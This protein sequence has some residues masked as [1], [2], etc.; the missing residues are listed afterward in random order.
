MKTSSRER[1]KLIAIL[2]QAYWEKENIEIGEQWQKSLMARI[3]QLGPVECVP[4]FLPTFGRFAWRLAPLTS[5]LALGLA[6][7]SLELD[8]IFGY[9]LFQ[10]LMNALED[11]TFTR[12]F[13]V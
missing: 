11:L 4:D 12:I 2:R 10:L 5:L 7:L 6:A 9:D 3:R 1:E 8:A 13:G